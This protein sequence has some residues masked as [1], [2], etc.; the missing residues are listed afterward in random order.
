MFQYPSAVLEGEG[1]VKT[2]RIAR[3]CPCNAKGC[4]CQGLHPAEG[5]PVEIVVEEEDADFSGE[6]SA[7]ACG[8]SWNKHGSLNK[9]VDGEI[10]RRARVAQRADEFL[11]VILK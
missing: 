2:I 10:E 9:L 5:Q 4:N 3:H 11:E 6:T 1:D 8:H 7:C